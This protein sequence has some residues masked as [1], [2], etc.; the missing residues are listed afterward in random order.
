ME[1][2]YQHKNWGE[3]LFAQQSSEDTLFSC[4]DLT[5]LEMFGV[6]IW[7]NGEIILI[8]RD[9]DG[10]SFYYELSN[11]TWEKENE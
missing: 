4:K 2:E 9:K 1:R 11:D 6:D 10:K 8:I 5:N 3:H 7:E